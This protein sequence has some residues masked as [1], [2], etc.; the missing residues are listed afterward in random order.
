MKKLSSII[1]CVLI[2]ST[3]ILFAAHDTKSTTTKPEAKTFCTEIKKT[4]STISAPRIELKENKS[5]LKKRADRNNLL[6]GNLAAKR[7]ETETMR[8]NLLDELSKR[9]QTDEQR[10]AITTFVKKIETAADAKD[11][12]IDELIKDNDAEA[13][14]LIAY[15]TAEI[16]KARKAFEEALAQAEIKAEKECHDQVSPVLVRIHAKDAL[17]DARMKLKDTLNSIEKT[18]V[19][20]SATKQTRKNE[21]NN[22]LRTYNEAVKNATED[23]KKEFKNKQVVRSDTLAI[24]QTKEIDGIKITFNGVTE[25]NRCPVDVT[26]ITAGAA[27]LNVT[28]SDG[29]HTVSRNFSS[30]EIP[31]D[32]YGAK[33]SIGEIKPEAISKKIIPTSKYRITFKVTR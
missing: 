24:A 29:T 20:T 9:A 23:L 17:N 12:A 5:L 26:C 7:V 1:T 27:T 3:C 8:R 11:T 25:D 18:K 4:F 15:R 16:S 31:Y 30:D 33:I 32:F 14:T 6:I 22:I 21:I 13:T 2:T 28:L 19:I 10:K